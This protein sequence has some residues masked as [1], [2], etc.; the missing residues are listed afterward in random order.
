MAVP[1]LLQDCTL[2][3]AGKVMVPVP[4]PDLPQA[5]SADS[6]IQKST[7]SIRVNSVRM[8]LNSFRQ[9]D[10]F[11]QMPFER[12]PTPAAIVRLET[13]KR[14]CLPATTAV[15]KFA[16]V[17]AAAARFSDTDVPGA[18]GANLVGRVRGPRSD[19]E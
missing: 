8:T 16:D 17:C 5:V 6:P 4:L 18:M 14:Q 7:R 10:V 9:F 13:A 1:Q 2:P 3:A 11:W 15:R 19:V 12:D